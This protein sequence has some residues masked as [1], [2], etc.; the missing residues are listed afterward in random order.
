MADVDLKK[1]HKTLRQQIIL[2][3]PT[4]LAGAQQ[5]IREVLNMDAMKIISASQRIQGLRN[6]VHDTFRRDCHSARLRVG[7]GARPVE[8]RKIIASD[9]GY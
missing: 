4:T 2:A 6:L 5:E 7:N 3:P 8:C 9:Q 1:V